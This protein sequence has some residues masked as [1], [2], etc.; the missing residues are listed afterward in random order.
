M[1]N[2]FSK[3]Q[4]ELSGVKVVSKNKIFIKNKNGTTVKN[5]KYDVI[6]KVCIDMPNIILKANKKGNK[7]AFIEDT[8]SLTKK[9]KSDI[10]DFF[11]T[12][13]GVRNNKTTAYLVRTDN[14]SKTDITIKKSFKKSKLNK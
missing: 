11:F 12:K 4:K 14:K 9:T 2:I 3:Y 1:S 8:S 5:K 13:Q 7:T 6:G 10:I